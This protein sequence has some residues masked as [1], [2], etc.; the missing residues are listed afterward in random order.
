M[1]HDIQIVGR[2]APPARARRLV[3]RGA[4]LA[5]RAAGRGVH[6]P[7]GRRGARHRGR[8]RPGTTARCVWRSGAAHP[9]T[10]PGPAAGALPGVPEAEDGQEPAA[11]RRA[12]RRRRGGRPRS[13][14]CVALGATEL[15]RASQGPY[16]V[17]DARRPGGQRVLRHLS[18][19]QPARRSR[20]S[21]RAATVRSAICRTRSLCRL[22]VVRGTARPRPAGR[23]PARW[24]APR[25][26]A[27][28]RDGRVLPTSWEPPLPGRP[29]RGPVGA[30]GALVIG[31]IEPAP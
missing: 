21:L 10:R 2:L 18:H 4:R 9:L 20:A 23:R 12:R 5:G 29:P 6:P 13:R 26:C 28:P 16:V 25:G 30:H 11:P 15:W 31:A 19:G 14:G 24:P 27:G 7:H 3:G 22:P 1:A 17:G 8:R